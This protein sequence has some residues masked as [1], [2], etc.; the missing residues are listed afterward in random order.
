MK[1]LRRKMQ[2]SRTWSY[3]SPA[4]VRGLVKSK[5]NVQRGEKLRNECGVLSLGLMLPT[6]VFMS[7]TQWKVSIWA[8]VEIS[9]GKL[10]FGKTTP[11]MLRISCFCS[12]LS[13]FSFFTEHSVMTRT[14]KNS[15]V[16]LRI[17]RNR[18]RSWRL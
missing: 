3:A 1:P 2:R 18:E 14:V 7:R 4:H 13:E 15:C 5:G 9:M 12:L 16:F 11:N 8:K 17:L 6:K 10:R